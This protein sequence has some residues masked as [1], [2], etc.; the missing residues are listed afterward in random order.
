[1]LNT[2]PLRQNTLWD[3]IAAWWLRLFAARPVFRPEA[4]PIH[5]GGLL[6]LDEAAPAGWVHVGRRFPI[7]AD[8]LQTLYHAADEAF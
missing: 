4:A 7:A 8:R 1:M 3:T 6:L 5:P 2:R